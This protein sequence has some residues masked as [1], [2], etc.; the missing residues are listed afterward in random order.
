M[1]TLRGAVEDGIAALPEEVKG[2]VMTLLDQ[3]EEPGLMTDLVAQQF[4]HE[5]E[6]RQKLLETAAVGER[7]QILCDFFHGLR[8]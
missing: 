8:T 7:V 6:L 5:V 1:K 2:G 3:A 4:V